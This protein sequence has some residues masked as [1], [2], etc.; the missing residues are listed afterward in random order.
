DDFSRLAERD[1]EAFCR[2]GYGALVAK[3]AEGL[4]VQLSTPA[5]AVDYARNNV[6]VETS[7]GVLTARAAILTASTNVLTG[8]AIKFRP[9]LPK[10]QLDA[11]AKLSLGSLDHIA[12]ELD[13][14]PLGLRADELVFEQSS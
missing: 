1:A 12:L 3:L 14:N 9:A 10:R 4:P 8:G 2:Q 7:R 5:T 13:G 11:L 6:N